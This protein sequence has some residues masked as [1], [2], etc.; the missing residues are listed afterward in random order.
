M[1]GNGQTVLDHSG[2]DNH[3]TTNNGGNGT[4]MDCSATGKY[5][6][7]CEFDG[8]DDV[9]NAGS[10]S[11]LD[12]LPA[13]G[14]TVSAW[15]YPDNVSQT[16]TI[17]AKEGGGTDGWSFRQISAD[18]SFIVPGDSWANARTN[19]VLTQSQWHHV[20]ATYDHAARQVR[21][22]V[23]GS[24][25]S[26][27]AQQNI[28]AGAL[29]DDSTFDLRFGYR[30]W[31]AYFDGRMDEMR[32][33]KRVL[34]STE[35]SNLYN[36]APEPVAHWKFDEPSGNAYDTSA[37]NNHLT[38]VNGA[39]YVPGRFGNA[40][41]FSPEDSHYQY[42]GTSDELS[43]TGDLSIAAWIMPESVAS[44]TQFN[45]A[46]KW[47][48]ANQSYLLSQ[49]EDEIRLYLGSESDY[50]A[51][52]DVGLTTG[53]WYHVQASYH[54]ASQLVEIY[55][56]GVPRT[57]STTGTIPTSL[58]DNAGRFHVSAQDSTS[59]TG[60][61]TVQV[62][63]GTDDSHEN[64]N[65]AMP[66]PGAM[67]I[68]MGNHTS[69]TSRWLGG[70]RWSV[71][72][73]QGSTIQAAHISVYAT[74]DDP[75]FDIHAQAA[76]D[77]AAF[78]ST[79]GDISGRP[80]TTAS[81]RWDATNLG[82]S[83]FI[84]SPD[85]SAVIQEVVDRPGWVAGNNLVIV[86]VPDG[87]VIQGLTARP[88]DFNTALAPILH[89][90]FANIPTKNFYDGLI[91]D[92]RI[93]NYF[94]SGSHVV[95]D[96]N[97]GHPAPGSPVGSALLH[98]KLDENGNTTAYNSGSD[99]T[100]Q[101]TITNATWV[102]GCVINGCVGFGA[103]GSV[104]LTDPSFTDGLT[105]FTASLWVNP[106]TLLTNAAIFAKSGLSQANNNAFLIRTDASNS[107]EIR[108]YI[109]DG[110][111][112]ND[113]FTTTN[114]DLAISTWY[115]VTVVYDGSASAANRI[116]VYKNGRPVA[117]TMTGTIPTS[118]LSSST[119][120]FTVGNSDIGGGDGLAAHY[121]DIK[122]YTFAMTAE[123]VRV[124]LNRGFMTTLGALSTTASGQADSSRDRRYCPPG[125]TETNCAPGLDASPTLEW[126]LDENTG[127]S[128]VRDTAGNIT[129]KN[130]TMNAMSSSS[131][132]PGAL[133]SALTFD[134]STSYLS[135]NDHNDL[136]FVSDV[137]FSVEA[138]F[139]HG[140][141]SAVETIIS[142]YE[143]T[144]NDGG[145]QLFMESNGEIT[146]RVYRNNTLNGSDFVTSTGISYD[147]NQWHH[148]VCTKQDVSPYVALYVDGVLVGTDTVRDMTQSL[149]NNDPFYVGRNGDAAAYWTGQID[150]V[151][152][153]RYARTQAQVS[154]SYNRGAPVGWWRFDECS[155]TTAYD[156][157]GNG[158]N[159]TITPGDT[160]G[161]ND[162][163]GSCSGSTGEMWFD[164]K[165]GKRN[166]SLEFDG[167]NDHVDISSD[168]KLGFESAFQDYS[169]FAWVKRAS[170][171]DARVI[172]EKRD[173]GADG[174][175]L[176]VQSSNLVTCTRDS[177]V[178]SSTSTISDNQ[179]HHVGCTIDR[180]GNGQVYIDGK[181]D[182]PPVAV[183]AVAMSITSDI[184][185]G[186]NS[187]GTTRPF[188]GQIDDVRVYN[189]VLSENQIRDIINY[190]AVRFGP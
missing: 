49:Y 129:A 58:P 145:Y 155:G 100:L 52:T 190:G 181:A 118:M 17:M 176:M 85:I 132:V 122:F 148:V 82:T 164:G 131:W 138:W 187:Y 57:T 189:Y 46:G 177:T 182:G 89:V 78:T 157:S 185:I 127:T 88:Y 48:N 124:E 136:D 77:A 34:S 117:G 27:Y 70:M 171:G 42:I 71:D 115:H 104:S 9:I 174:W 175:S 26:S 169:I 99:D 188:H 110:F 134:G 38:N 186:N 135:H 153:Y 6:G 63:A 79:T 147:D 102:T 55:V 172:I 159:G 67:N 91:D 160:S 179:W 151:A 51:T 156:A 61:E 112:T 125:N 90:E 47:D 10:A 161:S 105:S 76:D 120:N 180:G 113:Y 178:I 142:K 32:V 109:G 98:W 93:Y 144:G 45:I 167:T 23:N 141:A 183:S 60:Q 114:L 25:V 150:N 83:I 37:H 18:L 162:S 163:V 152:V 74:S 8:T 143:T 22:F 149:P 21:I 4:G 28:G 173:S 7:G 59:S 3:G 12:N 29:S 184:R 81:V 30:G 146:C 108:V 73:P 66:N 96:M 72:I 54:A 24:E 166:A 15:I 106:Q 20:L 19:S 97:A 14:L 126:T 13:N 44:S 123:Q 84:D 121:D 94:R 1:S 65:S 68:N 33:Y 43:I 86:T 133:G 31:D 103:G 130:G 140:T 101:G 11:S 69:A 158:N 154:W 111:D 165:E 35:V 92:V 36:W 139:K 16:R 50:V 137:G 75:H 39:V 56:N 119:A 5:G 41:G 128:T 170:F 107:D 62:A 64:A 95:E 40:A 2:N 168:V 87:S 116:K 53:Q 80:R